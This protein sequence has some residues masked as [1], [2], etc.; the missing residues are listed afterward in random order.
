MLQSILLA[1]AVV[2]LLVVFV[3][4]GV[5]LYQRMKPSRSAERNAERR[6][7][8][9]PPLPPGPTTKL[10]AIQ[11]PP[12]VAPPKASKRPTQADP[13]TPPAIASTRLITP[14]EPAPG[15]GTMAVEWYG[16]LRCTS[17]PLE[18]QTFIIEEDGVYIG[19]DRSLAKIV[20][21]DSRV[22]KRPVRIVPRDGKVWAIDQNS[23][24]GT[25]LVSS[26][27]R[28]RITEHQLKRG[29][30]IVLADDAATFVYQI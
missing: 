17:G 22:S 1:A 23:T 29:E 5:A 6:T 10:P 14:D 27:G 11:A 4:V 8:P 30:A 25:F 20:V 12:P 2:L 16:M 15:Q 28:E 19:R 9:V 26:A 3:P 24:N 18:G 7:E 21:E 13:P